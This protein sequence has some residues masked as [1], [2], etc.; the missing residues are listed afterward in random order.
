MLT[1]EDVL[2][3]RETIGGR[4]PRTPIFSCRGLGGGVHLKAELFQKTG[5]F[6]PRSVL[7]E[8]RIGDC[9]LRRSRGRRVVSGRSVSPETAAA[10]LNPAAARLSRGHT[11]P[12]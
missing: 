3:A 8:L 9:P 4:L 12:A 7:N 2:R 11:A 1:R 10:V 5:S 6:K